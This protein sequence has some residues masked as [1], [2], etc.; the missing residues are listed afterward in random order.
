[1]EREVKPKRKQVTR[2][3]PSGHPEKNIEG[4]TKP[5]G[6]GGRLCLSCTHPRRADIE[7]AI[8]EGMPFLRIA[9]TITDGHPGL[10]A[11]KRHAQECIPEIMARRREKIQ[12]PDDITAELV[13]S[14]VKEALEQSKDS[15][16]LVFDEDEHGVIREAA[17]GRSAAIRTRIEAARAAGE[18]CGLFKSGAKVEILLKSPEA[19]ELLMRLAELVCP[20]CAVKVR[21]EFEKI[22]ES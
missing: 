2:E 7:K 21:D 10:L 3:V 1:V 15:A 18:I 8:I 9:K 16:D 13:K 11:L 20:D 19:Q 6:T 12:E 4:D 22:L 14:H 5:R 17:Q